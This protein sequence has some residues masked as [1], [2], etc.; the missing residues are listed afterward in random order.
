[1]LKLVSYPNLVGTL[2]S[3][4]RRQDYAFIINKVAVAGRTSRASL[5][6]DGKILTT[7]FCR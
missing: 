1:M 3:S 4:V 2:G 7:M 6:A 5:Q